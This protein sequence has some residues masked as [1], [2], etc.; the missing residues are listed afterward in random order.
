MS[1]IHDC[2]LITLAHN[3]AEFTE[4]WLANL[5]AAP[6]LPAEVFLV[7][8]A[9]D[10]NTPALVYAARSALTPLGVRFVTWRNEENVGCSRA[11]NEPWTQ[12][13]GRYTVFMDNDAAVCSG[14]WL[15]RMIKTFEQRPAL[16]ILGPKLVYPFLPHPIQCAG[17][18]LTPQGRV[19]FR[20]RGAV[21][22]EPRFCAFRTVPLLISACWMMPTSLRER[23][24]LLDELFHPVQY[25][26]LDLCLRAWEAGLE[27]AY[28]PDVEVYHFEGITT[29]SFGREEYQRNIARNSIKFRQKWHS[30]FKTYGSEADAGDLRWRS[31]KEMALTPELDCVVQTADR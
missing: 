28:T 13:T 4:H 6:H 9:S 2:T 22:N 20:G 29:G 18:G 16:G 30:V 19:W 14:D 31:R 11:R 7:D 26:D 10:D 1:Q 3:G 15:P 27:V 17:A 24:G 5:A 23:V 25:E 21:R 12:A 8:N